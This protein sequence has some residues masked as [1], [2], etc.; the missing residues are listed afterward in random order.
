MTTPIT[1]HP[2]PAEERHDV[3]VLIPVADVIEKFRAAGKEPPVMPDGTPLKPD[4]DSYLA[5]TKQQL[6][7]LGL[8]WRDF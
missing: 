1:L 3:A 6:E 5:F 2:M 7:A 8:T 4:S